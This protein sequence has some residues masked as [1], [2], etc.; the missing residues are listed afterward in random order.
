[1]KLFSVNA[2]AEA[3]EK[4]RATVKRALRNT[5]PNGK[6]RGQPR[7]KMSVAVAA[8]DALPGTNY[9]KPRRH[10]NNSGGGDPR[11]A[12]LY[13]DIQ[14]AFDE[15]QAIEDLEQRRAV[16]REKTGPLIA[17]NNEHLRDWSIENGHSEELASYR[18][19]NLWHLSINIVRHYCEWTDE[20]A[21]DELVIPHDDWPEDEL[22][23]HWEKRKQQRQKMLMRLI[24]EQKPSWR[25][26]HA[27]DL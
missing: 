21:Y 22:K 16:A 23:E 25:K 13:D 7:W 2:I 9:E 12:K 14:V 10:S 18:S 20:E 11:I 3:L 27:F 1:M 17:Y 4:D 24:A 5:P 19:E 15:L 8:I 6:E 26:E